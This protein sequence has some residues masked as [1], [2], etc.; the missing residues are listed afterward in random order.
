M[1]YI[2]IQDESTEGRILN[3]VYVEVARPKLT[4]GELI[5]K[6]V[7]QEVASFNDL[8]KKA[9]A[10]LQRQKG[11]RSSFAALRAFRESG[12]QVFIGNQS[13]NQLDQEIDIHANLRVR[14]VQLPH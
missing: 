14:F 5:K 13:M 11:P 7:A 9:A 2:L 10:I 12:F 3:E 4:I 1:H 6:R 8:P